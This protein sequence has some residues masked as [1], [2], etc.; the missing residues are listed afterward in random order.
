M[1]R[2]RNRAVVV[3]DGGTEDFICRDERCTLVDVHLAHEI[4]DT[5]EVLAARQYLWGWMFDPFEP[6]RGIAPV[7]D[8]PCPRCQVGV[9]EVCHT[10]SGRP[11]HQRIRLSPDHLAAR[12][13]IR[14]RGMADRR[15]AKTPSVAVL[16]EAILRAITPYTIKPFTVIEVEVLNDYGSCE[17]RRLR[18]RLAALRDGGDIT[19]VRIGSDM[20]SG[21]TH[22]SSPLLTDLT[23]AEEIIWRQLGELGRCEAA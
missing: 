12:G 5:P 14:Q 23:H 16:D 18:R 10:P 22:P 7:I 15:T 8:Y 2:K 13:S 11:H 6:A 4:E 20:I 1:R 19:Y 9:G 3:W 17:Q 21:Y